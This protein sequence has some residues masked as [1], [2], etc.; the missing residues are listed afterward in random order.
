M[1]HINSRDDGFWQSLIYVTL[2]FKKFL[3]S[4]TYRIEGQMTG[5]LELT[6]VV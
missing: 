6:S 3:M 2:N 1:K 5:L 4:K